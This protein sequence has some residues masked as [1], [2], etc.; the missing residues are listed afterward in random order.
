L[1]G[2]KVGVHRT[3]DHKSPNHYEKIVKFFSVIITLPKDKNPGAYGET[4]WLSYKSLSMNNIHLL[5]LT[6]W[7][8][9]DNS[10]PTLFKYK[11]F[12]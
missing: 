12:Y 3:T 9:E 1:K 11:Q 5:Y 7:F 10:F 6:A 4:P 2:K 8:L